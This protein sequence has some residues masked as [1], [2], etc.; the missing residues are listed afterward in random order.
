MSD[1]AQRHCVPC[2]G[3]V[4]PL[5]SAAATAL[6]EQLGGGWCVEGGHHHL[7]KVYRFPD[8]AQALEFTNS[9]GAIAEAEGH[10]PDIVLAWGRVELNIWTHAIDGL[11]ESDFVLAARC[12][13]AL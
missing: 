8:F 3:G 2:G 11:T 9:V 1:L 13:A 5:D 12:D 7:H 6:L 4:P 10:H